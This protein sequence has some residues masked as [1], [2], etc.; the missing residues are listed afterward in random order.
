MK[1]FTVIGVS[2]SNR[3][4]RSLPTV[5]SK[6]AVG[7]VDVTAAACAAGFAGVVCEVD[8]SCAVLSIAE[9]ASRT[10]VAVNATNIP[11]ISAPWFQI[12]TFIVDS[13]LYDRQTL[14]WMSLHFAADALNLP[15][16]TQ[17]IPAKDLLNILRAVSAVEQGLCNL[18]QVCGRIHPLRSSAAHAIEVR[19]QAHM[20][21]SRSLGY[22][23]DVVDQRLERRTRNLRRPLPLDAVFVGVRDRLS[24]RLSFD[25]ILLNRCC[26]VLVLCFH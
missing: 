13:I 23:I 10:A 17:Q 24:F 6:T 11:R 19:A 12:I 15:E 14:I 9:N 21:H 16:H 4:Q 8:A 2:F 7:S 26:L 20:I 25:Q 5:V 18:R 3:V 1:F 22:V